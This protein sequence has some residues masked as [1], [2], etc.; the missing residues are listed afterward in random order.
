MKGSRIT[1]HSAIASKIYP[2]CF[3]PFE[4]QNWVHLYLLRCRSQQKFTQR[5]T[6]HHVSAFQHCLVLP[7]FPESVLQSLMIQMHSCFK[8]SLVG[9]LKCVF[10]L[11]RTYVHNL[12]QTLIPSKCQTHFVWRW[13]MFPGVFRGDL[14]DTQP[15]HKD[16]VSF[17]QE[18]QGKK[19]ESASLETLSH[20]YMPWCYA[21]AWYN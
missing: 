9:V 20:I 2:D 4:P 7:F 21:K 16:P 14:I 11:F 12:C 1:P 3:C 8:Q 18:N 5:R 15:I 13:A 19:L 17:P 10:F 6:F